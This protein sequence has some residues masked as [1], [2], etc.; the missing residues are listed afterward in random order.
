[1]ADSK[2][3]KKLQNSKSNKAPESNADSASKSANDDNPAVLEHNMEDMS[4][5][6]QPE[7]TP[8]IVNEGHE[9][10]VKATDDTRI[11][12]DELNGDNIMEKLVDNPVA[13]N[14]ARIAKFG[15]VEDRNTRERQSK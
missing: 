14:N 12:M 15:T 5:E 7:T 9:A 10:K 4:A 6:D 11:N 1:M 2:Q 13:R 8:E 3:D